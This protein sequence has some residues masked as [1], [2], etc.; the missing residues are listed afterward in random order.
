MKA[1]ALAELERFI[2]EA[3]PHRR[4][5]GPF[6]IGLCGAQGSGKSTLAAQLAQRIDGCAVLALDDL[7]LSRAARSRL[8]REVHPLL[9]TRGVPGTHDV[10]LGL[11]VLTALDRG[12]DVRVPQFDK[13]RDDRLPIPSGPLLR[14]DTRVLVFEGWCVG[15]IAQGDAALDEPVNALERD[16]DADGRWRR[17]V[18]RSLAGAYQRLFA[19]IDRQVLLAA[20]DFAVVGDWRA[21][22]ERRLRAAAPNGAGVLGEADIARF[23]AHYERLTR[24]ILAEMPTRA[25]LTLRLDRARNVVEAIRRT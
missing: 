15:A 7:Y 21:E 14:G 16:E 12:E 6:V 5:R 22:Q 11:A 13:A 2:D 3:A 24:H 20:P 18:D 8:A 4:A 1:T 17:W 23:V 25:A 10:E 19:R 9:R